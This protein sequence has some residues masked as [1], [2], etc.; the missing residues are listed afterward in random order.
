[1]KVILTA[2]SV[3]ILTTLPTQAV[4]FIEGYLEVVSIDPL[5]IQVED[6]GGQPLQFYMEET[7][8]PVITEEKWKVLGRKLNENDIGV[9]YAYTG[10]I[11]DI[12]GPATLTCS[13]DDLKFESKWSQ[14]GGPFLIFDVARW[15][16][17]SALA[18]T[19]ILAAGLTIRF[20][21]FKNKT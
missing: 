11:P 5:E 12:G 15:I 14:Q 18:L 16:I 13:D 21:L 19:V 9:R 17:L 10:T 20:G 6:S 3:F 2:F 7:G 4:L 1:M 8:L